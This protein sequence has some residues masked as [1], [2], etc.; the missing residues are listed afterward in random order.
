SSRE[1]RVLS[2]V[3]GEHP[4]AAK[5]WPRDAYDDERGIG[6]Q[7]IHCARDHLELVIHFLERSALADHRLRRFRNPAHGFLLLIG[8]KLGDLAA[9][10]EPRLGIVLNARDLPFLHFGLLLAP[11]L[12]RPLFPVRPPPRV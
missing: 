4:P 8:R 2:S 12:Q 10:V 11:G 3:A 6:T 7:S 1:S 5:R 9:L